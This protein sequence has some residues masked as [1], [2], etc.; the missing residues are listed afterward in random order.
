MNSKYL[1]KWASKMSVCASIRKKL[2]RALFVTKCVSI[3]IERKQSFCFSFSSVCTCLLCRPVFDIFKV[4]F[5]EKD[6][7]KRSKN[8][9]KRFLKK[10]K[11]ITSW[12]I[13]V[14]R[15][16]KIPVKT[17]TMASRLT[18]REKN[19]DSRF[20]SAPVQ[21]NSKIPIRL[22]RLTSGDHKSFSLEDRTGIK[23]P[24]PR[25][26]AKDRS[27]RIPVS[28]VKK[29][30]S[31]EKTGIVDFFYNLNKNEDLDKKYIASTINC[32]TLVLNKT[33]NFKTSKFNFPSSF[34]NMDRNTE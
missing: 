32:I 11:L 12:K 26:S 15:G 23:R 29:K 7:Q 2:F 31:A 5:G 9:Q 28:V 10:S 25:D 1:T 19:D 21:Q 6:S 4:I 24:L 34:K 27:S 30:D 18:G 13:L 14:W 8:N 33:N 20:H 16:V 22:T 3:V 17:T